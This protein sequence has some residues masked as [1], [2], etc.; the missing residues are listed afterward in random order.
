MYLSKAAYYADFVV[1]PLLMLLLASAPVWATPWGDAAWIGAA[2]CGFAA[3]SLLEYVLHRFV[4]HR[5]PPF[6][7]MHALHHE[8]PAAMIGTPTWV[9]AGAALGVLCLAW[10]LAGRVPACG[11]TFGLMLGYVWYG[12]VHHAVHHWSARKG[13]WLYQLKRRHNVHHYASQP[14]NYGVTTALWDRL[15]GS[16]RRRK[17]V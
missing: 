15:F 8:H 7:R 5:L 16:E 17:V 10:L 1:F 4:L 9:T 11:F 13:S 6:S 12:A 2:F 14:C 3:Y